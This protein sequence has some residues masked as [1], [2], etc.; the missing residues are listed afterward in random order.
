MGALGLL[1][2]IPAHALGLG[3]IELSSALNEPFKAEIPVNAVSG[4]EAETLQVRLASNDEFERAGLVKDVTVNQLKFTVSQKAGKTVITISSKKPI[5]EPL[6]DFLLLAKTSNGQLIREYT[7]LLDPPKHVFKDTRRAAKVVASPSISQPRQVVSQPR[8]VASQ[9]RS[10]NNEYQ[11]NAPSLAGSNSYGPTSRTDTLW[12]I[13]LKTRPSRDV[14]VHQMML[15][16][17]DKNQKAFIKQN[18]NGLKSGYTLAIPS[19]AD[20]RQISNQQ[21]VSAVKQQNVDWKNRNKPQAEPPA[22]PSI[23]QPAQ[24]EQSAVEETVVDEALPTVS[25]AEI[26]GDA[27]ARLQLLGSNDDKVLSD[28]DLAAFGN[29]KVKELSDQLTMAQEVIEGQQQENIDIKSRMAAMEEQIKTLRKLI[30]LQDPDLAK[31]QSK[32]EQEV[33]QAEA[34]LETAIQDESAKGDELELDLTSDMKTEAEALVEAE[35]DATDSN[36]VEAKDI[37]SADQLEPSAESEPEQAAV[38]VSAD[39]TAVTMSLLEKVQAFLIQHKLQAMLAALGLLLGLFFLG[40]KRVKDEEKVSWDEAVGNIKPPTTPAK[41]VVAAAAAVAAVEIEPE[42]IK[43]VD[44]LIKDADV[45]VSMGDFEQASLAL[46]EAHVDSPSNMSVIQKLLFV[47]YKQDKADEFIALAREYTVE[48]DSME[49]A[50]VADWGRELDANNALFVAPLVE[51][52][53]VELSELESDISF[54]VQENIDG[55]EIQEES[56]TDVENDLLDFDIETATEASEIS[57]DMADVEIADTALDIEPSDLDGLSLSSED[58]DNDNLELDGLGAIT[59]GELEAATLALS[60]DD[61]DGL[62]FDLSDFDQVDEAETKLD[63]ATAYIEMGD[64]EGAKSILKEIM[65]EGNDEQQS[66]ATTLLN[67]LT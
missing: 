17:V 38:D 54:D 57:S 18:I 45:Y 52:A 65:A 11:Y 10:V 62:E 59:D 67:E 46:E 32:L 7:V 16:L 6:L 14:S 53:V 3:N 4:D 1:T 51:E 64:P 55:S 29:E 34:D 25:G 13:A 9:P 35:N 50:E 43:T 37:A 33:A 20:I 27:V 47:H 39:D 28:N 61:A 60:G 12:D 42:P 48:R 26:E 41:P 19:A 30:E 63:L 21:A 40:R 66:R 36:D 2:A 31:L 5:K 24:V 23:V 22:T 15:A 56:T 8:Q 49:W 44:D 58:V